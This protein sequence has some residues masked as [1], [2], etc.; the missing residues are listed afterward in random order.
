M[1]KV[2]HERDDAVDNVDDGE[3]PKQEGDH[4]DA[5]LQFATAATAT[6]HLWFNL[7]LMEAWKTTYKRY[8]YATLTTT[9]VKF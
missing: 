2:L 8:L 3:D 7:L 5:M 1:D 6:R 9:T 4:L